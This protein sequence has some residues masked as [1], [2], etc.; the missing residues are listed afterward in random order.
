MSLAGQKGHGE[1]C[2]LPALMRSSDKQDGR[3]AEEQDNT[4]QHQQFSRIER[5]H[6]SSDVLVIPEENMT[7]NRHATPSLWG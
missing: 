2:I 7:P 1:H 3:N 4:D 6:V 5:R